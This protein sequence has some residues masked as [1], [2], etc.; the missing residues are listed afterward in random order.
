[1]YAQI[2]R[3]EC[4]WP[5]R[6]P[7]RAPSFVPKLQSRRSVAR[8]TVRVEVGR[9]IARTIALVDRVDILFEEPARLQCIRCD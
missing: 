8:Q 4:V 2:P 1:M 6:V 9:Q 7:S 5:R 3:N